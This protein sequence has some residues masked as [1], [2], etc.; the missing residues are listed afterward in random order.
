MSTV[1]AFDEKTAHLVK[2][3]LLWCG[4]S[5]AA[6]ATFGT[7]EGNTTYDCRGSGG[8]LAGD[9]GEGTVRPRVFSTSRAGL[10]L[11][12]TC[13]QCAHLWPADHFLFGPIII[14]GSV[15]A[16]S[17]LQ[18]PNAQI[19]NDGFVD[20]I[21]PGILFVSRRGRKARQH[22]GALLAKSVE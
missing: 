16:V 21:C 3:R 1:H 11:E 7:S 8:H 2:F 17:T 14:G 6:R 22:S 9:E 12:R 18:N 19:S 5:E 13:R 4:S 20:C 10:R 15:T